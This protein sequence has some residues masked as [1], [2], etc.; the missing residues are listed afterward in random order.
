LLTGGGSLFPGIRKILENSECQQNA[1]FI[2]TAKV[3]QLDIGDFINV[4]DK[5]NLLPKVTNAALPALVSAGTGLAKKESLL[6]S[7]LNRVI[8]L[9]SK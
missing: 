9:M 1:G 4:E 3:R 2:Q 5:T 7:V 6:D 8:R